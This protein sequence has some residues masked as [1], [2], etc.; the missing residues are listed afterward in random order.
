MHLHCV[1]GSSFASSLNHARLADPT[2]D[3]S[4]GANA[5]ALGQDPHRGG[6]RADFIEHRL[7]SLHIVS[8]LSIWKTATSVIVARVWR[9]HLDVICFSDEKNL[10]N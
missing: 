1:E 9:L 2:I 3:A 7:K 5:R 6:T 8:Y 10:Q 4:D